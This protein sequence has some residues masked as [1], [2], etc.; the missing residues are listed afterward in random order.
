MLGWL[1]GHEICQ[2]DFGGTKYTRSENSGENSGLSSLIVNTG[3]SLERNGPIVPGISAA[4]P[5]RAKI[6]L[7]H[8]VLLSGIADAKLIFEGRYSF[9]NPL[10]SGT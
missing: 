10:S 2:V 1:W 9:L 6:M 4:R 8:T 5:S 7:W 3:L